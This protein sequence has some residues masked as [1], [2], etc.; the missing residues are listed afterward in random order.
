MKVETKLKEVSEL[1]L[2]S[3]KKQMRYHKIDKTR[4]VKVIDYFKDKKEKE[5][6]TQIL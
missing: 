2:R 4:V 5:G 3:A 1:M 6:K